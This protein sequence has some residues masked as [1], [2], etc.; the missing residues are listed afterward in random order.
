MQSLKKELIT[1]FCALSTVEGLESNR[2][3]LLT[4][5]GMIIGDLITENEETET[6]SLLSNFSYDI[7]HGYREENNLPDNPLDGS[8]GFLCLKN[9]SIK[10]GTATFN[11]PYMNVFFDQIVGVSLGNI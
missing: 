6:N 9:V 4:P 8:D 11:I 10:S 5:A 2:V 1:R 3:V 7:A